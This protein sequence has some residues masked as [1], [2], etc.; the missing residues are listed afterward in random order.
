MYLIQISLKFKISL[1]QN[2]FPLKNK[3]DI[4]RYI[5]SPKVEKT[6]IYEDALIKTLVD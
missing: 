3:S 5:F 6:V 1:E 2:S 4:Y